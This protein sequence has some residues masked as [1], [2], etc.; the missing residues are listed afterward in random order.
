M[1]MIQLY[2]EA[3]KSIKKILY[4]KLEKDITSIAKWS[5]ETNF[6]FSTSKTKIYGTCNKQISVWQK[7]KD[8]HL[9]SN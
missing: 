9:A 6:V 7:L 5:I 4:K 2:I 8:E 3:V 1:Q